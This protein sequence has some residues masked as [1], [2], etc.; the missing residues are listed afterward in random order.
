MI[1][2]AVSLFVTIAS[3]GAPASSSAQQ[4]TPYK[5]IVA[6]SYGGGMAVID[7]PSAARCERARLT[8]DADR[9]ARIAQGQARTPPGAVTVGAPYHF[10]ATCIPG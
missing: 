6:F 3:V 1:R 2:M 4:A 7:Y 10:T 9:D 8:I 5:L